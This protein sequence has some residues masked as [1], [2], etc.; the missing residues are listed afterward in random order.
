MKLK[1]KNINTFYSIEDMKGKEELSK[2]EK[3]D[4]PENNADFVK[5]MKELDNYELSDSNWITEKL[6][7]MYNNVIDWLKNN[8]DAKDSW[9][10]EKTDKEYKIASNE[11]QKSKEKWLDLSSTHKSFNNFVWKLERK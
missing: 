9:V 8:P 1:I 2:I 4:D 11:L 5:D 3:K 7:G 10:M 6:K